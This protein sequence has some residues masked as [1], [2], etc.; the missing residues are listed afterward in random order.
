[1]ENN[2]IDWKFVVN[3]IKQEKCILFLGPE[4]TAGAEGKTAQSSFLQQLYLDN[5]GK[6][7]T[8]HENDGF[9]LF[10]SPAVRTR[11]VY[12]I[13][14][15]YSQVFAPELM[16]KLVQIPFHLVVSLTP[17]LSFKKSCDAA[18]IECKTDFYRKGI[19]KD[20]ES[21]PIANLPFVY[22]LFG[23]VEDL[24]GLIL[25]HFDLFDYVKAIYSEKNLPIKLISAIENAN[26]LIFMGVRFDKWYY[27]LLMSLLNLN[28]EKLINY[29]ANQNLN[30][31]TCLLCEK[32]FNIEFDGKASQAFVNTLYDKCR[33]AG[34][35][36]GSDSESTDIY[37]RIV[38]MLENDE[39]ETAMNTLKE[40]IQPEND[41]QAETLTLIRGN[42]S[43]ITKRL[44]KGV[45]KQAEATAELT[46]YRQGLIDL[47]KELKATAKHVS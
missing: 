2:E 29:S 23:S 15:F 1:M 9:L 20:L 3:S 11:L 28:N 22:N 32:F 16:N 27:Q 40:I 38:R 44:S 24:P 5:K 42:I 43:Y 13:E 36:R 19:K 17:D 18:G 31:Q 8:Y 47:T 33:E 6:I 39:T 34:L 26:N 37:D 4:I 41:D 7:L 45:V 10:E 25:S 35:L 12:Q 46:K 21:K 14:E 30:E